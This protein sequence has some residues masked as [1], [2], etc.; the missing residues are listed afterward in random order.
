MPDCTGCRRG[1]NGDASE[2]VPCVYLNSVA[3]KAKLRLNKMGVR[4]GKGY[5]IA[6]CVGILFGTAAEAAEIKLLAPVALRNALQVVIPEFEKETGHRATVEQSTITAIEERLRKNEYFDLAILTRSQI[7]GLERDGKIA[8]GALDFASV[9]YGMFVRRGSGKPDI[10]SVT[11]FRDVMLAA[12]SVGYESPGSPTGLLFARIF[13]KL[14]IAAEMKNKTRFFDGGPQALEAVEKG[15]IDFGFGITTSP[16]NTDLVA[17]LPDE[18]Q[19]ARLYAAGVSTASREPNASVLLMRAFTS[20]SAKKLL[21][22]LGFI[23]R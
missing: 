15:E 2:T 22:E 8:S 14:N 9:G 7:N 21:N 12:R 4:M 3:N 1:L 16:Y 23:T 13:E 17:P 5:A 20:S 10:T 19:D 18:I 11:K 6:F